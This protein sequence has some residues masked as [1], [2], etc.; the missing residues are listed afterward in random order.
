MST[1][2]ARGGSVRC[3]IGGN[4]QETATMVSS[5]P[6]GKMMTKGVVP[7]SSDPMAMVTPP[8]LYTPEVLYLL[9]NIS[10]LV[11][12]HW[13][14]GIPMNDTQNLRLEIVEAAEKI[15]GDRILGYQVGNEPDQYGLH[16]M[17]PIDYSIEDYMADYERVETALRSDPARF[18]TAG[19]KLMGPSI[20]SHWKLEDVWDAGFLDKYRSSLGALS[21]EYYPLNN[22]A[23]YYNTS[24]SAPKP[25]EVFA[26]YL[27]HT[28]ATSMVQRYLNSTAIAQQ[29]N[30]P[31]IMSETNSASCGGFP[32]VS[33]S[34]GVALWA[35]DY[36]LQLAVSNFTGA[37]FHV[38][39]LS[40]Y[41]N[42][43][44]PPP[45]KQS[46]FR[47]WTVGPVFYTALA[48][49]EVFGKSNKSQIIDLQMNGGNIYTPG[50]AV[51]D[52]SVLSR[53]ALFNFVDDPT[54]KSEYTASVTLSGES[55]TQVK[56][57]YLLAPSVASLQNMTW[58]GQSFGKNLSSDGR[59]S[60]PL[61]IHTV[62][63]DATAGVCA[64]RV[65]AP[66]FALVFLDDSAD[67][68]LEDHIATTFPTT[69]R[70]K[71]LTALRIDPSVLATSNGAIG[72]QDT[73]GST[74]RGKKW[75]KFENEK[76]GEKSWRG[77][78]RNNA[79]GCQQLGFIPPQMHHHLSG[80]HSTPSPPLYKIFGIWLAGGVIAG[81]HHVY[82]DQL[83]D[84]PVQNFVLF[85]TNATDTFHSQE[86]ASA[87]GTTLATLSS[88]L[89]AMS[90][91]VALM[92]YAWMRV[93]REACSVSGLDAL[94]SAPNSY[95]AFFSGDAWK[96]AWGVMFIAL[97]SRLFPLVVTFVPGTLTVR[98][99]AESRLVE[100]TVPSLE[101]ASHGR[102]FETK[103]NSAAKA[104]SN[105]SSL[106]L[107]IVGA[108]LLGGQPL[109]LASP[110]DGNCTYTISISAPSY[111]CT[112]VP[113]TLTLGESPP[114]TRPLPYIGFEFDGTPGAQYKDWDF[115]ATYRPWDL[116]DTNGFDTR[117]GRNLSCIA[118]NS[119]YEI[120]YSFTGTAAEVAVLNVDR[121]LPASLIELGDEPGTP[122]VSAVSSSTS[123]QPT[124]S[125]ASA[126]VDDPFA[127]G[128][129]GSVPTPVV[130]TV[131]PTRRVVIPQTTSNVTHS[132]QFN[133]TTNSYALLDAL[134]SYIVGD[135]NAAL[136]VQDS[137]TEVS[138]TYQLNPAT[139]AVTQSRMVA[140]SKDGLLVW[141]DG[142]DKIMESLLQNITLSV[143]ATL[144]TGEQTQTPAKTA[145]IPCTTFSTRQHFSYDAKRLWLVYG[146]A[147]LV[148]FL[149][150]LVGL[151]AL[152]Q[153]AFGVEGGFSDM[154]MATR[155]VGAR[156]ASVEPHELKR[157][158][159]LRYGRMKGE[160]GERYGLAPPEELFDEGMTLALRT[161][162]DSSNRLR[163]SRASNISGSTSASATPRQIQD[164]DVE[165]Q[166][167]Q[168]P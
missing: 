123:S 54:G 124:S 133:A 60:G 70:T 50:Y 162:K 9:A 41:Y 168:S 118:W 97:L 8:L 138:T 94:W 153:N 139:L 45:T 44:T 132:A 86:G 42:A 76:K 17:R 36:G 155:H 102:L 27:N 89:L 79:H 110:C 63:C 163:R 56:V 21:A 64:I 19:K 65:P 18:P 116:T 46:M 98:Q 96:M 15:L 62:P 84:T 57:K 11:N 151:Y 26:T 51:Y 166:P 31:F 134:Y 158:T 66:G 30:F 114:G 165:L 147:L 140:V 10:F 142:M 49:A 100:C 128:S 107:R 2:Q 85:H 38:G 145:T 4:T 141:A 127:G 161:K 7:A 146:L 108:T 148:A 43:F 61:S 149:C 25:Q 154:L 81:L 6:D 39:G 80:V 59:L 90:V 111:S 77:K 32:G 157:H 71:T 22:C 53:L 83:R 167:F 129:A 55:H 159:P 119:T 20:S 35:L 144:A 16:H 52:N 40:A 115:G 99:V 92:Q 95:L 122:S 130:G 117:E 103:F 156:L 13:Y 14:F 72:M 164:Q 125:S 109:P 152:R 37:H 121:H 48:A 137:D 29:Y 143:L 106:A 113:H 74:S 104:Y 131:P 91:G 101:L 136:D 5:L 1:L 58:A 12:V 28:S 112:D 47:G 93:R 68:A 75:W 69:A 3:R 126:S 24:V 73:L 82:N 150:D 88:A 34:F 120:L 87:V 23:R 105:P 160:G 67:N 33:N 135:V 78:H